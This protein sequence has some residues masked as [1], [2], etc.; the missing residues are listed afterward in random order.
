MTETR[1]DVD[2]S[3]EPIGTDCQADF[4]EQ[5]LDRHIAVIANIVGEIDS[6]HPAPPDLAQDAIALLQQYL[7][8]LC[9]SLCHPCLARILARIR[10]VYD[11]RQATPTLGRREFGCE[12]LASGAEAGDPERLVALT[13][14]G[15]CWDW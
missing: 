11:V 8:P 5:Y 2:L 7:V 1:R 4:R 15:S 6:G 3:A 10:Y 12:S 9:D 14:R 13:R